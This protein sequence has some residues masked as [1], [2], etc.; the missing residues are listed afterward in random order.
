MFQLQREQTTFRT[1]MMAGLTSFITVSYIVVVNGAMLAQAGMPYEAAILATVFSCVLGGL[2][3]AFWGNSPLILIP[4]MG[5]NAFFT[6]VLVLSFGLSWRQALAAV[7][8]AGIVFALVAISKRALAWISLIPAS[9]IHAMT[10]GIGIFIAFLGLE[11]GG[12]IAAS[13]DTF[14]TLGKLGNPHALTTILTLM[15]GLP[16][17]LRGVTGSF[18][19][20]IIA[21]TLIGTLFGIVDVRSLADFSLSLDGAGYSE[22]LWAFDFSGV[23]SF[24]FWIAVFSLSIVIIF[25][26]MATQLGMLPD[27]SKFARS[28]QANAFSIVGASLLGCSSTTTSGES[29]TGIAAGG[30]TGL[31]SLTAGLLFLPALLLIPF[32]KIIPSSAI[33]PILI[34]VGGLMVQKV[35]DIPFE[36][37][38]ESFPAYLILVMIP[39]SF[40][41]ANGIAIGFIAYLFLKMATGRMKEIPFPMYIISPLFLLYFILGSL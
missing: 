33:A 16:L 10:V 7:F 32:L 38:T 13:P 30:R 3:M 6:F 37:M 17:F 20:T 29:I 23:A 22:L 35:K 36:D 8:L 14:V 15:I 31:T 28:F 12:L 21:G 1:E 39:L 26:N 4:G 5:D 27:L 34:I 25:Q 40:S 9:L 19:I 41:V 2:L 18:L 24:Q 11:K